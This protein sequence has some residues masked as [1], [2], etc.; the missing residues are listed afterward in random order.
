MKLDVS[1]ISTNEYLAEEIVRED[2]PDKYLYNDKAQ[3]V[4]AS[5]IFD[6]ENK[7]DQ[8]IDFLFPNNKGVTKFSEMVNLM[9]WICRH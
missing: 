1:I 3:F 7:V 2:I 9:Y 8:L 5:A 6:S 4:F